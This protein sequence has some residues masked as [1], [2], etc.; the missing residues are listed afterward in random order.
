M[1][2]VSS[3]VFGWESFNA[4]RN[5]L[6]QILGDN[7]SCPLLWDEPS[8]GHVTYRA[9]GT[10]GLMIKAR[11]RADIRTIVEI[12]NQFGI[13]LLVKGNGSNLL[14]RDGGYP[15]LVLAITD[16]MSGISIDDMRV[17]IDAGTSLRDCAMNTA[18]DGL[19][20]FEFAADIP[21]T[22]GGALFMNAGMHGDT[23]SDRL[24]TATV[25][26]PAGVERC[27]A[28][29]SALAFGY[30]HST[31]Q[32]SG[33]IVVQASFELS[34]G[35]PSRL[36]RRIETITAE[37]HRKYPLEYPNAGSVFKRPPDNYA[38]A[39]IEQAGL[40]G[41]SLG[42]AMVSILHANFII[43]RGQATAADIEGLSERII[44]I[45]RD[46]SGITLEREI[47]IF[48]LTSGDAG[49]PVTP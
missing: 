19:A 12:V 18:G 20:G 6:Q 45:V 27:Y 33:D 5:E 3:T 4:V 46:K 16:G 26:T 49:E 42:D 28:T 9:G 13:P 15:G 22:L 8:A 24:L 43:N 21:G 35:D 31:F 25:I 40:K 39:L 47:R 2:H 17:T 7:V 11:S 14:I 41:F 10:I 23:I 34:P 32:D 36:M 29:R 38:G 30:R 44:A 37:R 1:G 48:G